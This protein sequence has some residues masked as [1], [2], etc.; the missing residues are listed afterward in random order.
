MSEPTHQTGHGTDDRHRRQHDASEE[1][2]RSLLFPPRAAAAARITGYAYT[3][4][5]DVIALTPWAPPVHRSPSSPT[6]AEI[7]ERIRAELLL[8]GPDPLPALLTPGRNTILIPGAGR[9]ARC[10]E[11]LLTELADAADAALLATVVYAESEQVPAAAALSHELLEVAVRLDYR[12]GMYRW[13]D[14]ALP[15]HLTRPGPAFDRLGALLEP[16]APH[17]H[18]LDTLMHHLDTGFQ[19]RRTAR[20]LGLHINTVRHRLERTH[21]LIGLDPMRPDD[22]WLL[23]SALI[24]HRYR[25]GG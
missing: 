1:L 2:A 16:L 23:R 17:A 21:Q 10:A 14:L 13:A 18:L 20:R 12:P 4:R 5:Y 11:E 3:D 25:N 7:I 24:A 6:D 22:S 19:P 9:H 8:D 15:Y